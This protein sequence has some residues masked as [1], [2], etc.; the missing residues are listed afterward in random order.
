MKKNGFYDKAPYKGREVAIESLTLTEPTDTTRGIRLGNFTQIRKEL[1]TA[2]EA[3]YMQN[4]DVQQELD[5]AVERS[6]VGLRR[7]EKTFS[8][9]SIN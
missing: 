7:F 8:G 4:G 2:L 3:I 9:V 1:S 5:K 6:N